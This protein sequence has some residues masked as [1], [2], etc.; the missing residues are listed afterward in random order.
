MITV[1]KSEERRHI[2]TQTQDTWM[3]FDPHS[4]VDP[5]RRGFHGL[6]CLNEEHVAPEM[7]L[8]PYGQK[9]IDLITYVREGAL[10][11]EDEAGTIS[12][13]E[14]GKFQHRT[15]SAGMWNRARSGSPTDTAQVFQS[16][17]TP[18]RNTHEANQEQKRFYSAER[19]GTLKLVASQGGKGRPWLSIRTCRCTPP[20]C[21]R[22]PIWFTSSKGAGPA[23]F[24]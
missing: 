14:A 16:S 20:S 19:K 3:T 10:I 9:D 22:E 5:L 13:M 15:Y 18:D 7:G 11:H 4:G 6:E 24:T 17:L 23:G 1:R 12:R 8:F 2:H 21:S